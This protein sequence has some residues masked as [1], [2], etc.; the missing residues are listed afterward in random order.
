MWR[1]KC[2]SRCQRTSGPRPVAPAGGWLACLILGSRSCFDSRFAPIDQ[3]WTPEAVGH[4]ES[5]ANP[6]QAVGHPAPLALNVKK[7]SNP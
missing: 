5:Q 3:S 6:P 1:E 2:Y 4:P 7:L